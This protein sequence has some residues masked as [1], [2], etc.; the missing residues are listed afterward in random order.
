MKVN[1]IDIK[2]ILNSTVLSPQQKKV[3]SL[4][5]ANYS[6]RDIAAEMQIAKETARVHYYRGVI[7]L[8][9]ICNSK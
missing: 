6:W 8:R 2:A 9:S 1:T 5:L 3:I 4:K 7:K